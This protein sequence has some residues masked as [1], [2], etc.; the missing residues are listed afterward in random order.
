ME[1]T[2]TTFVTFLA[3]LTAA[4]FVAVLVGW[5]RLAGGGPVRVSARAGSMLLVNLLVL[6]TAA[7]ALNAQ[8]LF[9]ASWQDLSGAFGSAPHVGAAARRTCR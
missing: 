4:V 1:L 3:L 9:F 5:G 6:M 2:S 8:F 7:T